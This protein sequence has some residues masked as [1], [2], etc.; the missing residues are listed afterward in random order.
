[1]NSQKSRRSS[2]RILPGWG[3]ATMPNAEQWAD[4][5]KQQFQLALD[6]CDALL[7]GVER[8]Q[9]AQ[10]EAAREI[11]AQ[12]RRSAEALAGVGDARAIL[13]AQGALA[14]A[15]WQV[16]MRQF[17][18]MGEIVQKTHLDCARI[19]QERWVRLGEDWKVAAA[20]P[21]QQG[22]GDLPAVWKP[23]LDAIRL[24]SE[25][26]MRTLALQAPWPY[27]AESEEPH[28]AKAA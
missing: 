12:N 19:L 11:Q 26:M 15:R 14:G 17:S 16:A 21:R 6:M 20:A 28:K 24:S 13:S 8:M 23:V 3:P 25:T 2:E 7:A 18:T 9:S 4:A 27:A 22:G 10:L 5:V 1:M